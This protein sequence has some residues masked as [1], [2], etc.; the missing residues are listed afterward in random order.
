MKKKIWT[1]GIRSAFVILLILITV[2]TVYYV[3][4]LRKPMS[5]SS[6]LT[7]ASSGVLGFVRTD[8]NGNKRFAG[9]NPNNYVCFG[10]E[11]DTCDEDHLYRMIGMIDGKPKLIKNSAYSNE[12]STSNIE[13]INRFS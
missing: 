8:K 13:K 12:L 4:N 1:I 9:K 10:I 5:L 6:I 7:D 3:R 2:F 11:G